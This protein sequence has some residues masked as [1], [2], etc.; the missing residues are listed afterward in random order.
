MYVN[1]VEEDVS[2]RVKRQFIKIHGKLEILPK[3]TMYFSVFFRFLVRLYTHFILHAPSMKYIYISF[4]KYINKTTTHRHRL[5]YAQHTNIHILC[6]ICREN[7]TDSLAKQAWMWKSSASVTYLKNF[8]LTR[9]SNRDDGFVGMHSLSPSYLVV[10]SP[11]HSLLLSVFNIHN[12]LIPA[13]VAVTESNS[14]YSNSSSSIASWK[15]RVGYSSYCTRNTIMLYRT[16]NNKC[17]KLTLTHRIVYKHTK[18]RTRRHQSTAQT[19]SHTHR[20]SKNER[21]RVNTTKNSI[22]HRRIDL[23]TN[24]LSS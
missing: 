13:A 19:H 20:V 5:I 6:W 17:S 3:K 18:I 16:A 22:K 9:T 21:K 7:Q 24:S 11:Q 4:H 12:T 2:H 23:H 1:V 15:K 14:N 10:R 8:L